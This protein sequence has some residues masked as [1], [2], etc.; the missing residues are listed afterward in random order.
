MRF[1]LHSDSGLKITKSMRNYI[2]EAQ[3]K[4]EKVLTEDALVIG[5]CQV[6]NEMRGYEITIYSKIGIITV[7]DYSRDFYHSVDNT[8]RKMEDTLR[9]SRKRR[10]TQKRR[11]MKK[12]KLRA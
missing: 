6:E 5:T 9:K 12:A 1:E 10:I 2:S 3:K 7:E 8:V 11:K 4:L